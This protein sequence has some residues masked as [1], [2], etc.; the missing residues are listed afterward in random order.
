MKLSLILCVLAVASTAL[1]IG[2]DD[3]YARG[4]SHTPKSIKVSGHVTVGPVS[5]GGSY[6]RIN[7]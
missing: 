3:A 1:A 4:K 7:R 2:A 5:V 6:T